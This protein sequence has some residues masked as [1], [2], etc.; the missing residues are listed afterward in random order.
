MTSTC[1]PRRDEARLGR[2]GR[3]GLGGA[4]AASQPLARHAL[5]FKARRAVSVDA[6][7]PFGR[8]GE[9]AA[10]RPDDPPDRPAARCGRRRT[11]DARG[12]RGAG[13]DRRARPGRDRF[14]RA[15]RR[16]AGDR[17][18][19]RPLSGG[20]QEPAR[21]GAQHAPPSAHHRFGAD[22]PRACALALGGLGGG[23]GLPQGETSACHLASG[24]RRAHPPA[25]QLRDRRRRGRLCHR[26][27][28]IRR[29]ARGNPLSL[30]SEAAQGRPAGNGSVQ[31]STGTGERAPRVRRSRE[32]G[33]RGA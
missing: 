7:S 5:V 23:Q 28:R 18:A 22:R 33:R 1:G 16:I 29:R 21:D 9:R 17:R 4:L 10:R 26:R 11:R 15:G 30:G 2:A 8:G 19:L 27:V 32:L 6:L 20:D 31:A 12:H 24:R 25:H 14:A 13:G 3:S